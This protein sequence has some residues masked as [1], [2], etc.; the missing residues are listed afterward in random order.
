MAGREG[1]VRSPELATLETAAPSF[2][3][4]RRNNQGD[5]KQEWLFYINI[6]IS[7]DSTKDFC[8]KVREFLCF[9]T[10]NNLKMMVF[11]SFLFKE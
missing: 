11:R 3:N 9:E 8:Q 2:V 6:E 7:W 10:G 5:S 4:F 1:E